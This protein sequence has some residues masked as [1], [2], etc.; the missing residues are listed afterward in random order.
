[1]LC[2]VVENGFQPEEC[3]S[4]DISVCVF[5]MRDEGMADS[6][7]MTGSSENLL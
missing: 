6:V 2:T 4:A 5:R 1:M 7:C 3:F